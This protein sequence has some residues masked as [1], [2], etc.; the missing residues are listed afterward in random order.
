MSFFG[1]DTPLIDWAA[2]WQVIY[3]SAIAG[4]AIATV[5]G[6]GITTALRSEDSSGTSAIALK[7]VT[8]VS[9]ILVGAAIVTGIY[10]IADK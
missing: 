9:V 5:L 6:V 8:V 10:F 4:L 2:L 7:G 1:A 3:I